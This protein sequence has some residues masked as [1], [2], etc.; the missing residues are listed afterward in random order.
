[1]LSGV[2]LQLEGDRLR[3]TGSD[4]D[5]TISMEIDVAGDTGAT[6]RLTTLRSQVARSYARHAN[7]T[8]ARISLEHALKALDQTEA[9]NE[10][11]LA[12]AFAEVLPV[13]DPQRRTA[14][15]SARSRILRSATRREAPR[16]RVGLLAHADVPELPMA[17]SRFC[18]VGL[19]SEAIGSSTKLWMRRSSCK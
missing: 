13:G 5:L 14:L 3:V 2:H 9:S 7:D 18:K 16:Q 17:S 1:V 19:S 12:L 15:T 4:L 10:A 8:D 6:N 11:Q